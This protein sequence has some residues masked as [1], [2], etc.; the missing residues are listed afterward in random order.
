MDTIFFYEWLQGA[1]R[2]LNT[3]AILCSNNDIFSAAAVVLQV[4]LRTQ[5]DRKKY[6]LHTT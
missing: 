2:K 1:S 6:T 5:T 3:P 4:L